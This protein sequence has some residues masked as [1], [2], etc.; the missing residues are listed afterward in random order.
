VVAAEELQMQS[1]FDAQAVKHSLLWARKHAWTLGS[2]ISWRC[3][4]YA[5]RST[6]KTI[7]GGGGLLVEAR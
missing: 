2:R 5:V 7:V 4:Y 3:G 6:A 1:V